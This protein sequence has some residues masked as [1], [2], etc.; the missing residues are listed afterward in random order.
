M[1]LV[2]RFPEIIKMLILI[3]PYLLKY[4]CPFFDLNL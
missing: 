2:E 3:K 4:Y 1:L